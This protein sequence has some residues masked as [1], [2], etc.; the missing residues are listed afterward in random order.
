METVILESLHSLLSIQHFL[1]LIAGI[2]V[3]LIVGVLPGMGG[4]AGMAMLLP[5]VYGME[6]TSALALMIG[7]LATT[8]AGDSFASILMGIPG[9]SSSATILDG[10]PLS[11]QGQAARAL[12]AAFT[13]SMMGG[14]FG[15]AVLTASI[16][17]AR[18]LILG[19]GMGE[20]LLLVILALTMVGSLTG[21]T[22]LKGMA[23]CGLGLLIGTIGTAPATG[24][25]RFTFGSIY[26]SDGVPLIV[27]ALGIFAMPEI[28][29][30]MR[31]QAP[32]SATSR[33]GSGWREGVRDS[34]RNW[35]LVLRVSCIGAIIGILPGV[36]GS[37]A[38][39]MAYGHVV[40]SSKDRSKFGKGDIRGVI[41]PEATNNSTR[42]GDLIPTL[43][44]GIPGSGSMAL[45]LGGFVLI[46]L[47]PGPRMVSDNLDLTF[48]IVWSLAIANILG[49]LM[50][51]ALAGPI[52]KLTLVPYGL[53]A[54]FIIVL[55]IFT[56][57]QAPRPGETLPR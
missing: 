29:D 36:G 1:Y 10:F 33:L 11:R 38:D 6:Q 42:A 19:V 31:Q 30:L 35:W 12:G 57:Y 48:V 41:A 8:A 34:F 2:F 56:A 50:C 15:V 4:A 13:S 25:V 20:R 18:P 47:D 54:P 21:P 49:A 51:I 43:F 44:F 39:W 55:M 53:L 24:Q 45:L 5:F 27:L 40:Q 3:G 32:I 22:P 28:V 9:G 7:M 46:G 26:L 14:V 17:I 37:M 16:Y 52:A 23:S